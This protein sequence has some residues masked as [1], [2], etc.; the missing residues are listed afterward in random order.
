MVGGDRFDVELVRV[1]VRV[2]RDGG[3]S[4]VPELEQAAA[5]PVPASAAS[6]AATRRDRLSM[7]ILHRSRRTKCARC[8]TGG[9]ERTALPPR[10]G[11]VGAG[12]ASGLAPSEGAV[13]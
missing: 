2:P 10:T 4:A 8:D 1:E 13:P 5:V 9:V 6:S 12:Q 11:F 7:L 3:G